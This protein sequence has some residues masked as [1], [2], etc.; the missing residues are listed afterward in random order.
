MANE[1]KQGPTQIQAWLS[2]LENHRLLQRADA[3][4]KKRTL[5]LQ[6][7]ASFPQIEVFVPRKPASKVC[8]DKQGPM[9]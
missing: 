1:I 3:M 6:S 9:L 8:I 4:V 2:K 5:A 7:F